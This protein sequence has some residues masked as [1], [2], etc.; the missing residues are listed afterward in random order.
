MTL[1]M[2]AN[3]ARPEWAARGQSDAIDPKRSS[4][5]TQQHRFILSNGS[6]L[7]AALRHVGDVPNSRMGSL[8]T[9][10]YRE[11]DSAGRRRSKRMA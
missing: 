6:R 9:C 4:A 2:S 10:V 7:D 3:R 5:T 11:F 8:T 1:R